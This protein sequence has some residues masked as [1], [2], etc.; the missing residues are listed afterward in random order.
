MCKLISNRIIIIPMVVFVL[1]SCQNNDKQSQNKSNSEL[2]NNK[3]FVFLQEY[4]MD[5]E[6]DS[7][8]DSAMY[9][10]NE[11]IKVDKNNLAAYHNRN[12]VLSVQHNYDKMITLTQEQ[13]GK[14]DTNDYAVMALFYDALSRLYYSKGDSV[15]SNQ[16]LSKSLFYYDLGL[17]KNNNPDLI[18]EYLDLIAFTKGKNEALMELEKY[19]ETLLRYNRYDDMKNYLLVN[20]FIQ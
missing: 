14:V 4:L 10:F 15:L 11:A 8:L 12:I 6:E 18:I 19:K 13:L 7:L 9:Y 5:K 1:T 3:G 17:E 2:L 20:D 16:T